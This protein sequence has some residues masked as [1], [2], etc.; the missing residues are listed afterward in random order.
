MTQHDVVDDLKARRVLH[1]PADV[2]PD[3]VHVDAALVLGQCTVEAPNINLKIPS[4]H[5][6]QGRVES[7][8]IVMS[9]YPDAAA[10]GFANQRDRQQDQGR[11]EPAAVLLI[12]L[13]QQKAEGK[14]KRVRTALL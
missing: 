11:S 2:V 10:N 12:P 6:Q 14:I 1:G 13:P 4:Q 5:F 8:L 7:R 3:A 9:Q